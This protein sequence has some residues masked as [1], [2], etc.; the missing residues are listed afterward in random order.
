MFYNNDLT[1]ILQPAHAGMILAGDFNCVLSNTDS[2]GHNNYSRATANIVHGFGLIDARDTSISR[3]IYT[4]YTPTGASRIDRIYVTRNNLSKNQ[5]VEKVPA[6]FTDHL[7]VVI[8]LAIDTPLTLR[9]RGYW[10]MNLSLLSDT[11][12]RSTIQTQWAKWKTHK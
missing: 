4:H 10:R 6:A 5:V 3:S 7:A 9:G 12:F 2:T 8:R 11:N 1:Y